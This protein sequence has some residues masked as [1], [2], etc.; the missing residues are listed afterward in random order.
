MEGRTH[1]VLGRVLAAALFVGLAACGGT[2]RIDSGPPP[3]VAVLS[4]FPAEM[5]PVL[6]QATVDDTV[7][8]N[9]RRFRI[10]TL[11]GVPVIIGLTGV[12]LVNAAA[13]THALLEQFEVA[14]IV[15][16]A[17]AGSALQIGDVTVPATW[18][19]ADGTGYAV[20][21]DWLKL[22]EA[23]AAPGAVSLERCTVPVSPP[24]KGTVCMLEQPVVVVGGVGQSTDPFGGKPFPCSPKGN[25]VFGCDVASGTSGSAAA[26]QRRASEAA[27][28]ADTEAPVAVDNETAAIAAEAAQRGVRFIAFRAVSDGAGDP[29]MLP[30]YP[31][32]FFA[33]Y[34]FAAQNAATATGAFLRRLAARQS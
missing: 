23:M 15:V 29:L 2:L 16:S 6:A 30:G 5:A 28:T 24:G 20:D 13:T 31:T 26:A 22:A 7:M 18:E 9:D 34:R 3:R 17:V 4:A 10:G 8:I 19:L 25:D 11:S 32:Q 33:Y 27:A 1:G 21:G 14:G 12:G